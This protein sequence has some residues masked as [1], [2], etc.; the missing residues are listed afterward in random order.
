MKIYKTLFRVDY[1]TDPER[2]FIE[3]P[4]TFMGWRQIELLEMMTS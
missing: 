1:V 2:I 4:F 3:T